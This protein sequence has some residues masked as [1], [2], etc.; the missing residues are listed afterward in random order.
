MPGVA[1]L[2]D[3]TYADSTDNT[4]TCDNSTSSAS[5]NA[6]NGSR[7][8]A[9]GAGV[10]APLGIITLFSIMW[11]LW[12]RPKFS[13]VKASV[14]TEAADTEPYR[15]ARPPAELSTTGSRA[16]ELDGHNELKHTDFRA[17]E[18]IGSERHY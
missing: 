18:P 3:V 6:S 7:D 10:G 8:V 5:T 16:A 14:F 11:A 17:E 13:Q 9:I 4:T 12:E 2:S 1:Y 15:P